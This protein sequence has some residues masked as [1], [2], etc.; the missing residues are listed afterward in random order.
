MSLEKRFRAHHD[1]TTLGIAF[2]AFLLLAMDVKRAWPGI[3]FLA[4]LLPMMD[5]KSSLE[6]SQ[7]VASSSG[8]SSR[9]WS[10]CFLA[11]MRNA[12]ALRF[13]YRNVSGRVYN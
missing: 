5:V 2:L 1:R 13:D 3:A 4:F 9:R 7:I 8:L 6:T 12:L 10:M 11:G